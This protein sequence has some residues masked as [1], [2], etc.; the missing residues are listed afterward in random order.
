MPQTPP[1]PHSIP[2]GHTFLLLMNNIGRTVWH[3]MLQEQKTS[4]SQELET[5]QF[6][7]HSRLKVFD[8]SKHTWQMWWSVADVVEDELSHY[9]KIPASSES[10]D[11]FRVF[12]F[13]LSSDS[14]D[15]P[16]ASFDCVQQYVSGNGRERLEGQ[17]SIQDKITV[18]ATDDSYQMTRE[19]M[20]QVE[21]D[22]WSRSA[23]E[24]KPGSTRPSK[25]P[26]HPHTHLSAEDMNMKPLSCSI[27]LIESARSKCV[28]IKK[29]QGLVPCIENPSKHSP[30]NKK[31]GVP[32]PVTH[33]PL[34]ERVIHLLALKPYSKAE[35]LLWLEKEK[36][37]P[38]DKAEL[39]AV[40]DEV[41]KL[42]PK[43]HSFTLKDD[44]YRHVRKDWPG[45][46]EEER[47]LIQRVLARYF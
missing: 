39:S 17:G 1:F 29:K 15:K 10:P 33:R 37:G 14:K 24:I 26:A 46:L 7:P 5:N 27:N 42:N 12:S 36:A 19:R 9:I 45:Y 25:S 44:F 35:L 28:K 8:I 23:I 32:G 11:S 41:A 4:T 3:R 16:Q 20:S 34:R 47:Q 13:Y 22:I 18:C 2:V 30:S 40:L 21:K 31:N 6:T 43:D 38:K